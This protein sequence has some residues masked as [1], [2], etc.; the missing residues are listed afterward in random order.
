MALVLAAIMGL[1]I[2][3]FHFTGKLLS[4]YFPAV[5]MIL[6]GFLGRTGINR[7]PAKPKKELN[8][9]LQARWSINNAAKTTHS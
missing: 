6:E 5:R 8:Y 4:K 9:P 1:L 2:W 7:L 3:I